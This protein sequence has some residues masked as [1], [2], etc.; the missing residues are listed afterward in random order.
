MKF[1]GSTFTSYRKKDGLSSNDVVRIKEDNFGRV[2]IFSYNASVSYIQ[3]N[4]IYNSGNSPFLNLLVGKG[5]ALD[6]FTDTNQTIH[7]YNWQGDVFSLNTKNEVEKASLFKDLTHIDPVKGRSVER[8]KVSF[9][10][11]NPDDEWVV[12]C[13][14]GIVRQKR[15]QPEEITI[16]DTTLYCKDVFPVGNNVRYVKSYFNELVKVSANFD[17]EKLNLPFNASRIRSLIVDTDGY[18][19]IAVYGEGVFCIKN[20]LVVR[21]FGIKDALGLLQDHEKNIWISSESDG[22]Y[23]INHDILEQNHFENS[24]F[25]GKG[26]VQLCNY[27]GNGILCTN[28]QT[29]FLLHKGDF[30]RFP[31]PE[32]LQPVNMFFVLNNRE[33]LMGARS[34]MLGTF[35]DINLNYR[36]KE[37]GFGTSEISKV[38]T[39]RIVADNTGNKALLFEQNRLLLLNRAKPELK[40]PFIPVTERVINAFYNTQNELVINAQQNYIYENNIL[41]PYTDLNRFKGSVI[42]DHILLPDSAELFNIDGDSL[43]ILKNH[44]FFNLSNAFDIPIDLQITNILFSGSTLYFTTLKDVFVCHN[45]LDVFTHATLNLEPLNLNFNNINDILVRDDTL[46]IASD[47]GLTLLAVS[48]VGKNRTPPPLPYLKSVTVNDSYRELPLAELNLT[49]KSS[50]HFSFGCISYSSGSVIYSYKMQ[51]IDSKWTVGSGSGINL[52]YQNLPRGKYIFMLRARK[53]NSGWSKPLKLL[54]TIRPTITEHPVFWA[55]LV[56]LTAGLIFL[57]IFW[58]RIQK[59]KKIEIDHQLIVYEQKA[60]HSMMNPHFIFN[61]LGS[62]QNYLLKNK[63]REAV[64]YL[65]QFAKLI[66]QNLNSANSPIIALD[67]ETEHLKNYLDLEKKRLEN[68]FEYTID[69]DDSLIKAEIYIP[70]MIIQPIAENAIW[71]GLALL[72][73]K[74]VININITSFTNNSLKFIIRDNGIGMKKSAEFIEKDSRHQQ[75]GMQIIEKRL[76]LL[77]KKYKTETSISFKEQYPDSFFPGTVV[78]IILPK[79]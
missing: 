38:A 29:V 59:M 69:V 34:L 61:S 1:D 47:D 13:G 56:F 14:R 12:W 25:D 60:L 3:N 20:N 66:R 11:K 57:I 54:V 21:H 42:S 65:S 7:F 23:M 22:V 49:G 9:L 6:F 64:I 33:L 10:S 39:K 5:F 37:F 48:S 73:D 2:W 28:T 45:P 52:V 74:G 76:F 63:G 58:A 50:I 55:L 53:S 43:F 51:G 70:S 17:K 75:L 62:I 36:R 30:L 26:I 15:W 16:I 68:K 41:N 40:A 8:G 4:K 27:P 72:K 18:L 77:G 46:Y 35:K 44:T 67:E 31:V 24:N 71:H 19:W 78:E 32:S 79:M